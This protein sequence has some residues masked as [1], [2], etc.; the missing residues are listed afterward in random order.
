M[1]V[2]TAM[3]CLFLAGLGCSVYGLVALAFQRRP[4]DMWHGVCA[5]ADGLSVPIGQ[6][7]H[8]YTVSHLEHQ[9]SLSKCLLAR[10]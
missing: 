3:I 9:A 1:H 6:T 7:P 10:L 8:L 5:T 4:T 2:S